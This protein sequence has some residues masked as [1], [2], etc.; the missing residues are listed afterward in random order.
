MLMLPNNTPSHLMP[1]TVCAF[2]EPNYPVLLF[3][4]AS[5]ESNYPVLLFEEA[6]FTRNVAKE[7]A[8][9][10]MVMGTRDSA[11]CRDYMSE[12]SEHSFVSQFFV[13]MARKKEIP[14]KKPGRKR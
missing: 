3:E 5:L 4:E 12:R 8:W 9:G 2:L 14:E 7:R 6:T 11:L 10:R 1:R 13:V